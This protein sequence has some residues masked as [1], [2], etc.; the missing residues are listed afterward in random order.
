M[1]RVKC[2]FCGYEWDY[3]GKR[4]YATCP[5]CRRSVRVQGSVDASQS[6]SEDREVGR[7]EAIDRHALAKVLAIAIKRLE[8]RMDDMINPFT[9]K[10]DEAYRRSAEAI[11]II[12]RIEEKLKELEQ[13][14]KRLEE[15]LGKTS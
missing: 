8:R 12:D 15:A 4:M 3:R 11:E 5:S 10:I 14:V 9:A 2:P 1:V 6:S 7:V 13:R